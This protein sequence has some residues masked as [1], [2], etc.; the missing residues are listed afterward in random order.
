MI[1]VLFAIHVGGALGLQLPGAMA[2]EEMLAVYGISLREL[3]CSSLAPT[4]H[5]TIQ[6]VYGY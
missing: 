1:F 2:T 6:P 4:L 5:N 3:V